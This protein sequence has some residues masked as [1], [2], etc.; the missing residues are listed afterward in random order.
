ML[1][2]SREIKELE[3]KLQE[4]K[5]KN[6]LIL[7]EVALR[8]SLSLEDLQVNNIIFMLLA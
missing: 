1:K 8:N 6:S 4:Y 7:H 2:L 3:S 5:K